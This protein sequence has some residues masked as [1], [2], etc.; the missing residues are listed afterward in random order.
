LNPLRKTNTIASTVLVHQ[1]HL[2]DVGAALAIVFVL[3][4]GF[5]DG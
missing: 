4:R 3:R 5:N 1:H 2:I